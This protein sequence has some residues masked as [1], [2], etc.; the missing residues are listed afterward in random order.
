MGGRAAWVTR[1]ERKHVPPTAPPL[2]PPPSLPNL[3]VTPGPDSAAVRCREPEGATP[4]RAPRPPRLPQPRVF[5]SAAARGESLA[6]KRLRS[7]PLPC[8]GAF[9]PLI[10]FFP[11]GAAGGARGRRLEPHV[12]RLVAMRGEEAVFLEAK[13]K[14]LFRRWR[15]GC[16]PGLC[17]EPGRP[18]GR[19]LPPEPVLPAAVWGPAPGW[20]DASARGRSRGSR[21]LGPPGP[22]LP[23][24]L[25]LYFPQ[26]PSG[27]PLLSPLLSGFNCQFF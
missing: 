19:T 15:R 3:N 21:R 14:G 9:S 27:T 2:L 6:R 20:G 23:P 25:R 10:L 26:V 16:L 18:L 22:V 13:E 1:G 17:S 11:L 24:L 4:S 12:E 7:R 5:R 8:S